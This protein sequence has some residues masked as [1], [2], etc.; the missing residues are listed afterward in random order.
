MGYTITPK[1]VQKVKPYL[2]AMLKA[3][4]TLEF[5]TEQPKQLA[6]QLQQAMTSA[7]HLKFEPYAS[8]RDNYT[9]KTQEDRI[10]ARFTDFLQLPPDTLM[11]NDA[12]DAFAVVTTIIKHKDLD[13]VLWFPNKFDDSELELIENYT[14]ANNFEMSVNEDGVRIKRI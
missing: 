8:L 5:A 4:S 1:S 10:I 12:K 11:F 7:V 2:D 14:N 3:K 9:I 6:Y 13:F